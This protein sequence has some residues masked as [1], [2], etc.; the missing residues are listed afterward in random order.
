[1]RFFSETRDYQVDRAFRR[2]RVVR[3]VQVLRL[4]FLSNGER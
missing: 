1:M 3:Y 2:S 4:L